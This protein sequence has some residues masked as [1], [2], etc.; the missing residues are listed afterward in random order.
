LPRR[1][2]AF[3]RLNPLSMDL[4]PENVRSLLERSLELARQGW[5]GTHPNP[6]VGALVVEHGEIV[7]EGFHRSAGCAHAEVEA[8][9]NLGRKPREGAALFVSL[10]PCSTSGR[11][12]PCTDAII[13]S[14]IG[15]VIVGCE[16]PNPSHAGRGLDL[17]RAAGIRVETAEDE[18]ARRATRLNFIFNHQVTTGEALVALKIAETSN[19]MVAEKQGVRSAVTG[20]D[21]LRDV[22]KWRRLFPAICVGA[23]TVACD[24]PSLTARIEGLAWSPVRI[25]V[26]G[27]LSSF[28][29][30]LSRRRLYSDEF[31]DRTIVVT[32][33]DEDGKESRLKSAEELGVR[34][35][36]TDAG[37]DGR[38][39]PAS[40]RLLLRELSLNGLYCEG[41]PQLARSILAEG[42]ADY[43]FRYRAPKVFDGPDALPGPDLSRHP[44]QDAIE[45]TLGED[46]LNHGFL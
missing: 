11:T 18:F 7:A 13:D 21:A 43:L 4:E 35:W 24:D 3:P 23:G 22:M 45:Q 16:D 30:N 6:M 10:E 1:L 36:R 2:G 27:S 12:P 19:G 46:H 14:G 31:A 20:E 28:S 15:T 32:S 44:L 26:D 39:P 33:Q 37:K 34:L 38:I 29:E 9:R 25:V 5:G 17:L 41:G 40:L 8:L 42:E